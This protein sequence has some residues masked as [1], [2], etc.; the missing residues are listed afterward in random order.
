MTKF[1]QTVPQVYKLKGNN[2]YIDAMTL[3]YEIVKE[4]TIVSSTHVVW[5]KGF[6]FQKDFMPSGCGFVEGELPNKGMIQPSV[7]KLTKYPQLGT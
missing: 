4:F 6:V 5:G 1:N 7:F 2:K 3:K